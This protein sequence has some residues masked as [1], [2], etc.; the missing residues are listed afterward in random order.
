MWNLIFELIAYFLIAVCCYRVAKLYGSKFKT[1]LK[2]MRYFEIKSDRLLYSYKLD[3]WRYLSASILWEVGTV[4]I[5]Y[6]FVT[7]AVALFS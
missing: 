5:L 7:K 3:Y 1:A 6:R 4:F 2:D